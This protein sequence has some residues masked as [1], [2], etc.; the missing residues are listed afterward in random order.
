VTLPSLV[1]GG[2]GDGVHVDLDRLYESRMLIQGV[3]GS[4]KSTAI[5]SLLE[6][7]HGHVPQLVIDFEGDFVTLREKFDY[8]L[9][10]QGGDVPIATKTAKITLRRLVELNVSAIFDLSELKFPDRREWVRIA[11]EELVHLPRTLQHTRL[12]VLDEAQVFAPERG[13]GESVATQAV[14][15]LVSLG[16]K[17]GL[18]PIE[19]CR[20]RQRAA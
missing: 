13:Q 3:P 4:G 19:S 9:V 7:T 2:R 10:G 8:V 11:C 18:V 14:I 1:F 12:I 20:I 15:D 6:Q 17:R 16:R 5:R